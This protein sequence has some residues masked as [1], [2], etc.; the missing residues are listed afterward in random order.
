M[1]EKSFTEASNESVKQECLRMLCYGASKNLKMS[2]LGGFCER[3]KLKKETCWKC[4]FGL[5]ETKSK[6]RLVETFMD[7]VR[8]RH[9]LKRLSELRAKRFNHEVVKP[10]T[11]RTG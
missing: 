5:L 6:R 8:A 3:Q 4:P 2:F 9:L 1:Q 7:N 11:M 10:S